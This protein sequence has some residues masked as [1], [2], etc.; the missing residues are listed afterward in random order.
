MDIIPFKSG[1][2]VI[3]IRHCRKPVLF[4]TCG[5]LW[6]VENCTNNNNI[7]VK[8]TKK[9]RVHPKYKIVDYR[10]WAVIPRS[11]I[12]FNGRR[13]I[14]KSFCWILPSGQT[15]IPNYLDL[16]VTKNE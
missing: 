1:Q 14:I 2:K 15:Y 9:S 10:G 6:D 16:I 3:I 11:Q 5:I 12:K 7:R 8:I 4:N 13:G